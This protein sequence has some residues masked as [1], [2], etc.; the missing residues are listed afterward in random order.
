M[1]KTFWTIPEA[2]RNEERAQTSEPGLWMAKSPHL[3]K[4]WFLI[5]KMVMAHLPLL[6]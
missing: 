6:L 5:W 4:L 3:S 2:A 1:F